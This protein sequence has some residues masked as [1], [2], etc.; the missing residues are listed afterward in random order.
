MI[1]WHLLIVA[2]VSGIVLPSIKNGMAVQQEHPLQS[3]KSPPAKATKETENPE[4]AMARAFLLLDGIA[5]EAE[6]WKDS[7]ATVRVLTEV[8]ELVWSMNPEYAQKLLYRAVDAINQ[9]IDEEGYKLTPNRRSLL[10][11]V[12]RVAGQRDTKL[13][14]ALAEKFHE[15]VARHE[16]RRP[17]SPSRE[18]QYRGSAPAGSQELMAY[19]ASLAQD[20]PELAAQLAEVSLASGISEHIGS[21]VASLRQNHPELAARVLR[22]AVNTLGR[23]PQATIEDVKFVQGWIYSKELGTHLGGEFLEQFFSAAS[24]ILERTLNTPLLM[25][26]RVPETYLA[27]TEMLSLYDRYAPD[28]A[29]TLRRRLAELQRDPD[30]QWFEENQ[31]QL[32]NRPRGDKGIEERLEQARA[33]PT[34]DRRD[35]LLIGIAHDLAR[36][37][38]YERAIQIL[39]EVRDNKRREQ[40]QGHFALAAMRQILSQGEPDQA[41]GWVDKIPILTWRARALVEMTQQQTK[42]G[43]REQMTA[44][45]Q[46]AKRLLLADAKTAE[47]ALVTLFAAMVAASVDPELGF[48][49]LSEAISR[50]NNARDLKTLGLESQLVIVDDNVSREFLLPPPLTVKLD[51][52]FRA[53]AETDF[54]RALAAAQNFLAQEIRAHAVIAVAAT[55]LK[56]G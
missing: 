5:R 13:A 9:T 25:K 33:V 41:R 34:N 37:R 35:T 53:L 43:D 54:E 8:A 32:R 24:Q 6:G 52:G 48:D 2:L 12:L 14:R 42:N 7:P 51:S 19:A 29:L 18:S 47:N 36:R 1:H 22:A 45:L 15:A 44:T 16:S 46:E 27:G 49:T 26:G 28:R 50:A 40:F 17:R 39:A 10:Q 21:L 23:N 55:A 11:E 56:K 20:Q 3:A 38:N 4:E 31:R 30:V